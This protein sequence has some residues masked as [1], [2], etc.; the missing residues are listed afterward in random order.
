MSGYLMVV[1][2]GFNAGEVLLRKEESCTDK[3]A[4]G[5]SKFGGQTAWG[6]CYTGSRGFP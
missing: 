5:I 1:H 4:G 2:I 6:Y 3:S